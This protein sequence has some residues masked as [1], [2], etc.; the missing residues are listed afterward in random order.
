M[1]KHEIKRKSLAIIA[2]LFGGY[3]FWLGSG[4]LTMGY[5]QDEAWPWFFGV[6]FAFGL[7]MFAI[8]GVVA[9]VSGIQ[10]FRQSSAAAVKR[11]IVIALV[12][13]GVFF[14]G[15][16]SDWVE[17]VL[18]PYLAYSVASFFAA[19]IMVA[20]YPVVVRRMLVQL[21]IEVKDEMTPRVGRGALIFLAWMLWLMLSS[22]AEIALPGKGIAPLLVLVCPIVISYG[23]YRYA[24]KKLG[25]PRVRPAKH[26]YAFERQGIEPV[27]PP[28]AKPE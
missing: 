18:E 1:K 19:L 5:N 4:F 11:I 27:Y 16:L 2:I 8:P 22:V 17:L 25:I 14:K 9:V 15:R 6:L 3:W 10:L 23:A 21:G 26:L 20:I 13:L 7:M 12:C 28:G 24:E